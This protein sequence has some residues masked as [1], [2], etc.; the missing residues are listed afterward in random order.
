M[1]KALQTVCKQPDL[2]P[3]P[4]VLLVLAIVASA[5]VATGQDWS[6]LGG[7]PGRN[8]VSF[9]KGV[10]L[11]WDL[12]TKKNLKWSVELGSQTYASPVVAGGKVFVGT[13]NDLPR[14]PRFEGDRGVL[15][16]FRESNGELLWQAISDKLPGGGIHDWPS[17]GVCSTPLVEG[18]RLYYVNNR[19]ELVCLDTEGFHDAQNDGLPTEASQTLLDADVVWKLDMMAELGV[20]PH[21]ASNSS[22]LSHGDLLFVG[23]SNGR[24]EDHTR[25]PSPEAPSLVAVDKRTGR[26]IWSDNSPGDAILNGQWTSPALGMIG[27]VLQVVTGQGDGWVRGFEAVTGKKL[28]EFDTNPKESV[29]PDSRNEILATPVVFGDRVYVANGQDPENGEGKGRLVAIDATRRG[30]ITATGLLWDYAEIR[31]SLSTPAIY[32]GLI[33]YPDFSGFFHCLDAE[34]GEMQWIHDTFAAVWGS[35]I[36]IDGKVF[37]GDED[38]DV[39]ILRAGRQEEV[40][41]ENNVEDAIYSTPVPANNTLFIATRGRL[42]AIAE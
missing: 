27:G 41:A 28:W 22:P 35:P 30:D 38:G 33:Y 9:M 42:L 3:M 36:V 12:R 14:D 7:S 10:P 6:M 5:S 26:V 8:L 13:N 1:K 4:I 39:V 16:A 37:L 32:E 20:F 24:S 15:M 23:T 19:D 34:T 40:I 11:E 21:N 29:Y 31:R 18:D 2:S 25:V 17:V